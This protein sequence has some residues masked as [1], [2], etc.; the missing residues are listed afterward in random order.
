MEIPK[1]TIPQV[2]IPTPITQTPRDNG[3]TALNNEVDD[4]V[5]SIFGDIDNA[6]S[7]QTPPGRLFPNVSDNATS[8]QTLDDRAP[9]VKFNSGSDI[10]LPTRTRP[11]LIN[12]NT[13][14]HISKH[15]IENFH[16]CLSGMRFEVDE[17]YVE[18]CFSCPHHHNDRP[19][20]KTLLYILRCMHY[21]LMQVGRDGCPICFMTVHIRDLYGFKSNYTMK[22]VDEYRSFLE[23]TPR[24]INI[25]QCAFREIFGA[26]ANQM[27][28]IG[29]LFLHLLFE[30]SCGK[31]R[32][33]PEMVA[34]LVISTTI[35]QRISTAM[36]YMYDHGTMLSRVTNIFIPE[37]YFNPSNP[38][39]RK[40]NIDEFRDNT[41]GFTSQSVAVEDFIGVLTDYNPMNHIGRGKIAALYWSNNIM[42]AISINFALAIVSA[43]Y[44]ICLL[45]T[46]FGLIGNIYVYQRYYSRHYMADLIY[47]VIF[48]FFL[49]P[50]IGKVAS[51]ILMAIRNLIGGKNKKQD[52]E[53]NKNVVIEMSSTLMAISDG[54]HTYFGQ[55]VVGFG[56]LGILMRDFN[57]LVH[58]IRNGEYL[59]S[60]IPKEDGYF[61]KVMKAMSKSTIGNACIKHFRRH[62]APLEFLMI[63]AV[64]MLFCKQLW[65]SKSYI[66]NFFNRVPAI[67]APR[68]GGRFQKTKADKKKGK[69]KVGRGHKKAHA[70]KQNKPKMEH[71][72]YLYYWDD[73]HQ[74]I[75]EHD[76]KT[77]KTRFLDKLEGELGHKFDR[78]VYEY[79]PDYDSDVIGGDYSDYD[80]D[81]EYE[82]R[83]DKEYEQYARTEFKGKAHSLI[84]KR[85]RSRESTSKP[86]LAP[87]KK[88][89]NP[90]GTPI[91]LDSKP[92][93]LIKPKSKPVS[94]PQ[95][96][97][98]REGPNPANPNFAIS[99]LMNYCV[100][101]FVDSAWAY[102]FA[103]NT[104]EGPCLIYLGHYQTIY[105]LDVLS[106]IEVAKVEGI[107]KNGT[108]FALDLA[109]IVNKQANVKVKPCH[110]DT[111]WLI[112][113]LKSKYPAAI[114]T[115][116]EPT[117]SRIFWV[118]Q[119]GGQPMEEPVIVK[120]NDGGFLCNYTSKPG[121]CGR[122]LWQKHG[123][124]FV[125]IGVHTGDSIGYRDVKTLGPKGFI[126]GTLDDHDLN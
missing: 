82:D 22:V 117:D 66:Y 51:M 59:S 64:V 35:P 38:K 85:F 87:K 79:Y 34:G 48:C 70:K 45:P 9:E 16:D 31:P 78:F 1:D 3:T 116:G 120:N 90:V 101:I 42:G 76:P 106:L 93:K 104:S 33:K 52:E 126:K 124:Q 10:P 98:K 94:S 73:N 4:V 53:E 5:E 100:K 7:T 81:D 54:F 50:M 19:V 91:V 114:A 63:N 32:I 86:S 89:P 121:D 49:F 113:I 111:V 109:A 11:R 67:V 95:E 18:F 27:V 37:I 99:S 92:K 68:E 57:F 24:S 80:D 103:I 40:V 23:V 2:L 29:N 14:Y 110:S 36:E 25:V 118:D 96:V 6:T 74:K 125:V 71:K 107:A 41:W 72:G 46:F 65:D 58:T 44:P 21:A 39:E 61:N 108:P 12:A 30:A 75:V 83:F 97:E 115:V 26:Q 8:T 105:K 77:H 47:S 62:G 84:P 15:P 43:V 28:L 88:I 60:R 13:E 20:T 17:Q 56:F 102:S 122:P 123:T 55:T 119:H 112:P 69:N